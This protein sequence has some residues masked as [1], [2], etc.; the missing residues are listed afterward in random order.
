MVLGG[1]VALALPSAAYART[2]RST[3]KAIRVEVP[4]PAAGDVTIEGITSTLPAHRGETPELQLFTANGRSLPAN[5]IALTA[6]RPERTGSK[7]TLRAVVV[8]L[9]RRLA[10]TAARVADEPLAPFGRLLLDGTETE[11][12]KRTYGP[13]VG[14]SL[15][16]DGV[17]PVTND[18]WDE[19]H[20]RFGSMRVAAG[21]QP[22]ANVG[23]TDVRACWALSDTIR[24]TPSEK[25]TPGVTFGFFD[26]AD[27]HPFTS[28]G[29]GQAFVNFARDCRAGAG[30]LNGALTPVGHDLG[31]VNVELGPLPEEPPLAPIGKKQAEAIVL[32]AELD[33]EPEIAERAIE[34]YVLWTLI[35]EI[36]GQ[37]GD[38]LRGPPPALAHTAATRSGAAPENGQV[39]KVEVRGH[40]VGGCPVPQESVC[41][42]NLHFQDLRPQPDGSLEVVSTTQAFTLPKQPG[43]YTYAP[44]NFYVQKGDYVGLA[45]VGGEYMVLINVPG[46]STDM[47]AGHEKDN[48]GDHVTAQSSHANAELNMRVTLQPTA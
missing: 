25:P 11:K 3:V 19:Q 6:T 14:F 17:V 15:L 7:T 30:G 38:V 28:N 42:D 18:A 26:G 12:S 36:S 4:L 8:V 20:G 37:T 45:T 21:A 27:A 29:I 40:F 43:T 31:F 39:T 10:G 41:E 48:N 35:E 9:D 32:G 23:L 5:V 2:K 1:V 34:D 22:N 46:A 33:E 16:F 24:L 47:F 13:Y 44:T